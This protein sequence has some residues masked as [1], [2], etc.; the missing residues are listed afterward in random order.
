MGKVRSRRIA[1]P[2]AHLVPIIESVVRSEDN[3]ALKHVLRGL[4]P[5]LSFERSDERSLLG[6]AEVLDRFDD[7]LERYIKIDRSIQA[8]EN[9]DPSESLSSRNVDDEQGV[10]STEP[11]VELVEMVL[12]VTLALIKGTSSETRSVYNSTEH[13]ISLLGARSPRVVS[14][15]LE[16]LATLLQRLQKPRVPRLHGNLELLN[17]LLALSKGWGGREKSLGIVDCCSASVQNLPEEG[18]IVKFEFDPIEES[19]KQDG[20]TR[21]EERVAVEIDTRRDQGIDEVEILRQ[22]EGRVNLPQKLRFAAIASIRL[23]RAF[24]SGLEAR[25]QQ[26]NIRVLALSAVA[27]MNFSNDVV[28]L[29]FQSEGELVAD[30]VQAATD[31]AMEMP[32][33][34][35]I[36]LRCNIFRCLAS[37]CYERRRFQQISSAAGISSHHGILPAFVRSEIAKIVMDVRNQRGAV[38]DVPDCDGASR[39]RRR[40]FEGALVLVRALATP[41]GGNAYGAPSLVTSGMIGSLVPLL[42]ERSDKHSRIICEAI[43]CLCTIIENT[44]AAYGPAAFRDHNGI[45]LLA[46]R[47]VDEIL[48]GEGMNS[49]DDDDDESVERGALAARGE[50]RELYERL[51]RA[52]PPSFQ[53]A[54][55]HPAPSSSTASRGMLTQSRWVLLRELFRLLSLVHGNIGIAPREMA[56]GPL[57]RALRRVLARPFYY[58]GGLFAAAASAATDIA[59]AEPTATQLLAEVG[60]PNAL[61]K[62]ISLG[63][64]PSHEAVK[65]IPSVLAAICL[66]SSGLKCVTESNPLKPFL[67]RLATPF[68]SRAT[69]GGETP[70]TIGNGLDELMRHVP[71]LKSAGLEAI[72]AFLDSASEF[73]RTKVESVPENS[74]DIKSDSMDSTHSQLDRMRLG[75][76]YTSARLGGFAGATSDHQNGRLHR[77][78]S[79]RYAVALS[80][81][82]NAGTKSAVAPSYCLAAIVSGLRNLDSKFGPTVLSILFEYIKNDAKSFL[83]I[84]SRFG[85]SKIDEERGTAEMPADIVELRNQLDEVARLLRVDI[86]ILTGLSKGPGFSLSLWEPTIISQIGSLIGTCERLARWHLARSFSS[87]TVE[88]AEDYD[89]CR[90][91]VTAASISTMVPIDSNRATELTRKIVSAAG[92]SSQDE[93]IMTELA[94]K[95]MVPPSERTRV[96]RTLRGLS[97]SLAVLAASTERL[98]VTLARGLTNSM[99]RSRETAST[100][101]RMRTFAANIARTFVLHLGAA[102]SLWHYEVPF[103]GDRTVVAAW[104][105]LRGL[106]SGMR[107]VFFD[108]AK[109]T[110]QKLIL[111]EFCSAGGLTLLVE[112]LRLREI[113]KVLNETQV[114]KTPT[115]V[116]EL[117]GMAPPV[118]LGA[119]YIA[120]N[121]YRLS[122]SVTADSINFED[123]K[124]G[125]QGENPQSQ[126]EFPILCSQGELI[127]MKHALAALEHHATTIN[128]RFRLRACCWDTLKACG[129]LIR[130]L[131]AGSGMPSV[132]PTNTQQFGNPNTSKGWEVIDLQRTCQGYVLEILSGLMQDPAILFETELSRE[133]M[134]SDVLGIIQTVADSSNLAMNNS[135]ERMVGELPADP[136][137]T[138]PEVAWVLEAG[139]RLPDISAAMSAGVGLSREE[140]LDWLLLHAN[141]YNAEEQSHEH[142]V[143]GEDVIGDQL[144]PTSK[145]LGA[146]CEL[147]RDWRI[148]LNHQFIRQVD[149]LKHVVADGGKDIVSL[150]GTVIQASPVLKDG[151]HL[152]KPITQVTYSRF[153][154]SFFSSVE[155]LLLHSLRCQPESGSDS[156]FIAVELQAALERAGFFNDESRRQCAHQMV[157]GLED[158]ATKVLSYDSAREASYGL[159]ASVAHACALWVRAGNWKNRQAILEIGGVNKCMKILREVSGG[160]QRSRGLSPMVVRSPNA[161]EDASRNLFSLTIEDR[162]DCIKS[163]YPALQDHRSRLIAIC[164][165]FLDAFIRF[166]SREE[167]DTVAPGPAPNPESHGGLPPIRFKF[168]DVQASSQDSEELTAQREIEEAVRKAITC[169][170]QILPASH[171]LPLALS[172]AELIDLSIEILRKEDSPEVVSAILVLVASLTVD[173][174]TASKL[175][176]VG[177]GV[178]LSDKILAGPAHAKCSSLLRTIIRHVVE[179]PDTLEEAMVSELRNV[180]GGVRSGRIASSIR[181]IVSSTINLAM[182]NSELYCRALVMTCRLRGSAV[183]SPSGDAEVQRSPPRE[184]RN[185]VVV[186]RALLSLLNE[187]TISGK[188]D[189]DDETRN[190]V[191]KRVLFAV[192]T[193]AELVLISPACCDVLFASNAPDGSNRSAMRYILSLE[194]I[195]PLTSGS[196]GSDRSTALVGAPIVRS[197][198]RRT[199]HYH[200][201]AVKELV[202][203][204]DERLEHGMSLL[205][206]VRTLIVCLSPAPP[207]HVLR[208][209]IKHEL[210]KKLAVYLDRIDA[211]TLEGHELAEGILRRLEGLGQVSSKLAIEAR[212]DIDEISDDGIGVAIDEATG[213]AIDEPSAVATL[214]SALEW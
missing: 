200:V 91:H 94:K 140:L 12:T 14:L 67:L 157:Q 22:H 62:S 121:E 72:L 179:D 36:Y 151:D 15:A 33:E 71:S 190:V 47:I 100:L 214:R 27:Q 109:G 57:P 111:E 213:M 21:R 95:Q 35:P 78:L 88:T 48:D 147:K 173:F 177:L 154:N 163:K 29:E 8:L 122:R 24:T 25:R 178:L 50:T 102:Q 181:S 130:L 186:V 192:E 74:Q 152:D 90:A 87:L 153:R 44:P 60:I 110:T 108:E 42:R 19:G 9:K 96:T 116:D 63:L 80:S 99:K 79:L 171:S 211:T 204:V 10:T 197:I 124:S 183:V 64:P 56:G 191:C 161:D 58:G 212:D 167:N 106:T 104:D 32:S 114:N 5:T 13:L 16:I 49:D 210:D 170:R 160:S 134:G 127:Q 123:P 107:E 2:S 185:V 176:P 115:S 146:D 148:V 195:L 203:F 39:D 136:L 53:E 126:S 46:H 132:H 165:L 101:Q 31:S 138:N 89:F 26:A 66:S 68:Y 43:R 199:D 118:A 131:T 81:A 52:P 75:V 180:V 206:G 3:D 149:D 54:L 158:Y 169:L 41:V 55:E 34:L 18:S 164:C 11:D 156:P 30:L 145:M 135:R 112:V 85:E 189:D 83:K 142:P 113:L 129:A 65:C 20:L 45:E 208:T 125:T 172:R 144:E 70:M 202:S 82:S 184:R 77:L 120:V 162:C 28:G 84:M 155:P 23:S 207:A 51:G 1:T 86:V 40:M 133:F 119:A 128:V 61:L 92:L 168:G 93:S 98:Y 38:G 201:D 194:R 182:R 143:R 205:P 6:W 193:L 159:H 174:E 59:H 198:I 209:M 137:S 175:V 37:I 196:G 97:W 4:T 7:V 117:G 139:F 187:S 188:T 73:A 150:L 166:P 76:T 69:F 17:R 103:C 105:Y 141:N